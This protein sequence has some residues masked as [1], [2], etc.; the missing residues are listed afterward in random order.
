MRILSYWFDTAGSQQITG[1]VRQP[2]LVKLSYIGTCLL[3]QHGTF[4]IQ[5]NINIIY[6]HINAL[7]LIH[8]PCIVSI[9]CIEKK[10]SSYGQTGHL[11]P[12]LSYK[13]DH[14]LCILYWKSYISL[15]ERLHP[16]DLFL[17]SLL[18][19]D[20]VICW[21]LVLHKNMN[22]M[23]RQVLYKEMIYP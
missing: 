20:L 23:S 6:I 8:Y 22:I 4:A 16:F 7:I 14:R 9:I 18:I 3:W 12:I 1:I 15:T 13:I 10:M 11:P 2:P 21:L 17:Q 19:L 5:I